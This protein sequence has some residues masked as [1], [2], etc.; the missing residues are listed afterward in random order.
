MNSRDRDVTPTSRILEKLHYK[1][2]GKKTHNNRVH[3]VEYE[4]AE[5]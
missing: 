2:M 1:Y 5:T 3:E 4:L